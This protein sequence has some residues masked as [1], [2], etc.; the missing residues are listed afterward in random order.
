MKNL[1]AAI[2]TIIII[3]LPYIVIWGTGNI[4]FLSRGWSIDK[5]GYGIL[6]LCILAIIIACYY[7]LFQIIKKKL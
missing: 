2:L 6:F 4:D 3:S 1:F 5:Y 7:T